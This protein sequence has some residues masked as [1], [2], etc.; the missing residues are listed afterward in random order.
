MKILVAEDELASRVLLESLLTS[1]SFEVIT[2]ENGQVALD[3]L[4]GNDAPQLAVLDWMMPKIDGIDVIQQVRSRESEYPP[5]LILLTGKTRK[6]DIVAGLDAGANDY[7]TKPFN[8][9]ELRARVEVGKRMI[10]IQEELKQKVNDLNDA[11]NEIKT[12]K[13]IVPICAGCKQIRDD[14]GFWHRVESYVGRHTEAKFSHSMCPDCLK[15]YYPNDWENIVADMK[16]IKDKKS[17]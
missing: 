14:E 13:G 16:K 1:L 2:A 7:I 8:S 11:F 6:E 10:E 12:L 17:P 15:A 4:S 3:I 5:Y 9:A